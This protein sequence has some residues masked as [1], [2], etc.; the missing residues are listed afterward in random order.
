MVAPVA[1]MEREGWRL[2]FYGRAGAVAPALEDELLS[3]VLAAARGE[4]EPVLRRSRYAAT[5]QVR[6]A[7]EGARNFIA[8]VKLF[9]RPRGAAALKRRIRGSYAEYALK[10]ARMLEAAGFRVSSVLI[11]GDERASGRAVLVTR[12]VDG[13]F[14]LRLLARR[15]LE[16]RREIMRALGREVARLH[17]AG[18]IHGDLTPFNVFVSRGEPPG[19]IFID[20]ERT[21]R[22]PL[23]N[24][25][26]AQLRNLVQLGRFELNGVSRTDRMRLVCAWADAL[27]LRNR[28]KV[29]NSV[30]RMLQRRIGRDGAHIW[31]GSDGEV[32]IRHGANGNG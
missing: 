24:R 10:A 31:V 20:H 7:A 5:Y 29:M 1:H 14:I 32:A 8:Y 19:F 27:G 13:D 25:R 11:A 23:L 3:R 15:G 18:F 26:R 9:D 17:L 12:Q 16:A 2:G 30:L 21:R 6:L 4:L 28:R 22:A